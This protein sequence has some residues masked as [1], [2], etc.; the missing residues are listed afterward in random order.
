MRLE[1]NSVDSF[2]GVIGVSD[3]RIPG[4]GRV[5]EV[6]CLPKNKVRDFGHSERS[7]QI[8]RHI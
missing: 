8:L 5:V 4:K 2:D 7:G 6:Y 1:S 3:L